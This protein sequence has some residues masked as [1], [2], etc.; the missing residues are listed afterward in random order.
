MVVVSTGYQVAT[1]YQ[2]HTASFKFLQLQFS[3]NGVKTTVNN[4]SKDN[5]VFQGV[6]EQL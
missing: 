2:A 1:S 6:E 4:Q 5:S 3:I